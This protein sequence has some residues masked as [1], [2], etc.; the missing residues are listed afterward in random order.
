MPSI[1]TA[2]ACL[3][4]AL[5][6][7]ACS[8]SA[9]VVISQ[10]YGGGGN[11]TGSPTYKRDFVEI[12]N[13]G[14][15]S[16]SLSGMSVQ[17]G[18]STGTGNWS[19]VF[20][21]SGNIGP[22]QYRLIASGTTGTAGADLPTADFSG[23][24]N[25][26]ASAGKIALVNSTVA[27]SG[28]C[29]TANALDV[30]GYGSANCSE[31]SPVGALSTTASAQRLSN[32]CLDTG[33]N[34]SD[35][36]VGTPVAR[37]SSTAANSCSTTSTSPSGIASASNTLLKTSETV[38]FTVAVTPGTNPISTGIAVVG[39]L[40]S[41]GGS[42]TQA[43][44]DNGTNGDLTAND[45][46]YSFLAT[47]APS[48]S[49]G[50][51]S[52]GI[53]VADTQGRSSNQTIELSVVNITKIHTVQ[54][55]GLS[56]ALVGTDVV[57]EGIVTARKDNGFFI[58]SATGDTDA[59]VAT[60]EGIFVFTGTIVPANATVFAKVRVSGR[61][62]EFTPSSNPHQMPL[63]EIGNNPTVSV[64]NTTN[65]LPSP[66]TLN[67]AELSPFNSVDYMERYEGM[68]VTMPTLKVIGATEGTINEVQVTS[69]ANG[70]F[71]GTHPDNAR[72][73]REPGIAITDV[74]TIPPGKTI[75]F[76][77]TNPERIRVQSGAQPGSVVLSPDTGDSI[78]NLVGVLD[79]S[80][81]AF[82]ILPD[83]SPAPTITLGSALYGSFGNYVEEFTISNFNLFRLYDAVDAP[84]ISEPVLTT[85]GFQKR[86]NKISETVCSLLISP[87]IL[88]V[89]DV[90]N[91]DVLNALAASINSSS[92]CSENPEYT[93]HLLNGNSS[94]GLNIGFLIKTRQVAENKPRVELLSLQQIGQN[95]T[96]QNPNSTNG[97]AYDQPPLLIEARINHQNGESIQF[98]IINNSFHPIT[99]VN[100]LVTGANGWATMGAYARSRRAAQAEYLAD[101]IQQRAT[102]NPNEKIVLTG[103]FN[104]HE[105]SDGYVD[106][107]GILTG[108]EAEAENV[109]HYV[110]SPIEQ[111]LTNLTRS[112][113]SGSLYSES[114]KGSLE[115]L[116]H[117]LVN[118][119]VASA[120]AIRY[121]TT[122]MNTDFGVDLFGDETVLTRNAAREVG[123]A[124]FS[125]DAFGSVDFDI[126]CG[127]TNQDL[128]TGSIT[129]PNIIEIQCSTIHSG[130]SFARGVVTTINVNQPKQLVSLSPASN[131]FLQD[132]A[133][134]NTSLIT[135]NEDV[136][137]PSTYINTNFS[138]NLPESTEGTTLDI[139]AN[140]TS[141]IRDEYP[142]N[143]SFELKVALNNKTDARIVS[144]VLRS[145]FSGE[146]IDPPYPGGDYNLWL[147]I[148]NSSNIPT[149][150]MTLT[151]VINTPIAN[152][153]VISFSAPEP[154]CTKSADSTDSYKTVV[155]CTYTESIGYG[156]PSGPS[157]YLFIPISIP[158]Q[159]RGKQLTVNS[160]VSTTNADLNLSNNSLSF[161]TQVY[162][163]YTYS[164]TDTAVIAGDA[165]RD[166][167]LSLRLNGS[168]NVRE[169]STIEITARGGVSNLALNNAYPAPPDS[170]T[171][172]T[173]QVISSDEQKLIC[174]IKPGVT[175]VYNELLRVLVR[176][177]WTTPAERN[178][179]VTFKMIS[180]GVNTSPGTESITVNIPVNVGTDLSMSSIN[181]QTANPIIQ[182]TEA[183]FNFVTG[184]GYT[185]NGP[186]NTRIR[187]S[188]SPL[189]PPGKFRV[190]VYNPQFG[191]IS[192]LTGACVITQSVAQNNT[193]A[194]CPINYSGFANVYIEPSYEAI[195]SSFV[196][197]GEIYNDLPDTNLANNAVSMSVPVIG[198]SNLSVT[199][200]LLGT[201]PSGRV[202][203]QG[204]FSYQVNVG[205]SGPSDAKNAKVI[206][207]VGIAA[208]ALS[209][210]SAASGWTCGTPQVASADSSRITCNKSRLNN[211][212][213][214]S[215]VLSINTSFIGSNSSISLQATTSSDFDD[216]NPGNNTTGVTASLP[217]RIDL[218]STVYVKGT[219][220]IGSPIKFLLNVLNNSSFQA[221]DGIAVIIEIESDEIS[222]VSIP[223][224][225]CSLISSTTTLKR[226]SCTSTA[227]LNPNAS[228]IIGSITFNTSKS[229]IGKTYKV[230]ISP[231]LV[232]SNYNYESN[233]A[234]NGSS[235]TFVAPKLMRR[236]SVPDSEKIAPPNEPNKPVR[237]V[238]PMKKPMIV[239]P[240]KKAA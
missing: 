235:Y 218:T 13:R 125:V 158:F 85:A 233:T 141:R 131:C 103:N 33:N 63:T 216:D 188:I 25:F 203:Y 105:F 187:Y 132:G 80:D 160:Q 227:I 120:H 223:N 17:Y 115:N 181:L 175:Y 123:T 231:S 134:A 75:P 64:I 28:A 70:V 195:D 171:C 237:K 41:I 14:T 108:E 94:Q 135:C 198:R 176:P 197:S 210:T 230:S 201:N 194:D 60:S 167:V 50:A 189:L 102:S 238:I 26:S 86:I 148:N 190:F 37:N 182:G 240:A 169:N 116:Q 145:T 77:D 154:S 68:R 185:G 174:T 138:I 217:D 177:S 61:V 225:T 84:G 92:S 69:A 54:G 179:T 224:W 76:F 89:S 39:N 172:G 193:L 153:G 91:I 43:F 110:D 214:E 236:Q 180:D 34:L 87:D 205:N 3:A 151:A 44:N 1:R 97:F 111:P 67:A 65:P 45:N 42:A 66:V 100:S 79:Y 226:H 118:Q 137:Y 96:L 122:R 78:N 21:L 51:K 200:T 128:T 150:G 208:Q 19:S 38:R 15:T 107:M 157:G 133:A 74:V 140:V 221:R 219:P 83:P 165:Y 142:P 10:V 199:S 90:E 55:N 209:V 24:V 170:Y 48:T 149:E 186:T 143:N 232:T 159:D 139:D 81:A 47:V 178:L 57:V 12:F 36:S 234:N 112:A 23:S 164:I 192:E 152:V 11:N 98:T 155:N 113:P 144:A 162:N 163:G 204:V 206:F 124:H 72:P 121:F 4:L 22:G 114:R 239:R 20:A 8:A 46:I 191:N 56:S 101:F 126:W 229:A 117:T 53:G 228:S 18:S 9:Q 2:S 212:I 40:T 166:G 95:A 215:I 49:V 27:L 129:V 127:S 161:T 73:V 58:Q 62:I 99:D 220:E 35:F 93:A 146:V 173:P 6:F 106:V 30:I 207:D 52:I 130:P 71:Y 183:R 104:A 88:A 82:T 184:S 213:T 156:T 222:Q 16:V 119:N 147:E 7:F 59:D 29:P 211:A 31:T 136:L 109:L 32:G 202:P 5:S 168:A 196:I